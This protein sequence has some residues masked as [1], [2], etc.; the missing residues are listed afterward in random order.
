MIIVIDELKK[1]LKNKYNLN[2]NEKERIKLIFSYDGKLPVASTVFSMKCGST[3]HFKTSF[4]IFHQP[5]I[6]YNDVLVVLLEE[7]SGALSELRHDLIISS[8]TY[9]DTKSRREISCIPTAKY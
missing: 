6:S 4:G 1:V 3:I 8:L 9:P 5:K 2:I 7:L